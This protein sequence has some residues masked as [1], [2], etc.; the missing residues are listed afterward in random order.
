MDRRLLRSRPPRLIVAATVTAT[1]L[2]ACGAS[3]PGPAQTGGHV[4][5]DYTT[6]SEQIGHHSFH[7]AV[8]R[9]WR[10]S[11]AVTNRASGS[12]ELMLSPDGI[13]ALDSTAV[14][15]SNGLVLI[16]WTQK[17]SLTVAKA[18]SA[19]ESDDASLKH[20]KSTLRTVHIPGARQAELLSETY[21]NHHG[22]GRAST[23]ILKTD[24]GALI[25]IDAVGLQ[26]AGD[27][28]NPSVTTSSVSI[29]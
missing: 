12:R 22:T 16:G 10:S 25:D 7:L 14:A 11:G 21:A 28:Y 29:S 18:I 20:L 1:L 17:T 2:A 4:R 13:S 19:T 24:D 9:S 3:G 23:L 5:S 26:G 6:V 27:S 8:P 15:Y